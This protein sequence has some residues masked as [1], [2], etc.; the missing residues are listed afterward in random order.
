MAAGKCAQEQIVQTGQQLN[1]DMKRPRSKG[2]K[3]EQPA[4]PSDKLTHST[5]LPRTPLSLTRLHLRLL[6]PKHFRTF[7]R[8]AIL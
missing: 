2:G 5:D 8:N 3:S 1:A 4:P 7:I 6:K